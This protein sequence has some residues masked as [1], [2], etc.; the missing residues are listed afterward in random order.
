MVEI[1]I[2]LA[3]VSLAGVSFLTALTTVSRSTIKA[4]RR[5]HAHSL[6]LSQMEYI[7]SQSYDNVTATPQYGLLAVPADWSANTTAVRLDPEGDGNS[8]DDGIQEIT[9]AIAYKGGPLLQLATK[10][11]NI[12]YVH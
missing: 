5:S 4:D 3:L 12:T 1:I 2:A 7:L 11:V 6:A 10:K 9:V 8:D